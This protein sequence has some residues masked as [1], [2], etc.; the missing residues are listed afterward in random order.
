ML[1][2][3][4]TTENSRSDL[5]QTQ[6]LASTADMSSIGGRADVIA[7]IADIIAKL[8]PTAPKRD[9]APSLILR[10]LTITVDHSMGADQSELFVL[11]MCRPIGCV[12]NCHRTRIPLFVTYV[13]GHPMSHMVAST[14]HLKR[15]ALSIRPNGEASTNNVADRHHLV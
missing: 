9:P 2:R 7:G 11:C 13:R 4:S 3:R 8:S 14:A 5:G 1:V 15:S 12:S 6:K 10:F